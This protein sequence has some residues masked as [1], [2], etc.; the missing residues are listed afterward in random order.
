MGTNQVIERLQDL[1]TVV[2]VKQLDRALSKVQIALR[3]TKWMTST[4]QVV[5]TRVLEQEDK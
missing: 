4:G 2:A 1:E 3:W 5:D